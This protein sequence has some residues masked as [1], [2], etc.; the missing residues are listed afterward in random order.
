MN[1]FDTHTWRQKYLTNMILSEAKEDKTE[2]ADETDA[3]E[4]TTDTEEIEDITDEEF[5]T[6]DTSIDSADMSSD[7]EIKI[8]NALKNLFDASKEINDPKFTTLISNTITYFTKNHIT[9][10]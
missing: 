5:P 6:D 4:E 8:Q 3:A 7:E 9:K 1:T 10:K 2:P